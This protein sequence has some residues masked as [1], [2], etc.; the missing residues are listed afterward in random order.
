MRLSLV[1]AVLLAAPLPGAAQ[2]L[3]APGA[4]VRVIASD[5][6]TSVGTLNELTADSIRIVDAAQRTLT[7]VRAG[8][9]VERS[10]GRRKNFWKHFAIGTVAVATGGALVSAFTW[11]ECSSCWIYPES[12]A[13]AFAWG[14]AAGGVVGIPIGIIAGLAIKVERWEPLALPTHGSAAKWPATHTRSFTV[15]AAIPIP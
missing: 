12:R 10:L 4:R 3:A 1:L 7:L 15:T 8:A 2:D 13:E 14:L 11:S 5:G 9:T 6:S